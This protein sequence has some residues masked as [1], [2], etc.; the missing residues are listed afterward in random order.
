MPSNPS[1]IDLKNNTN[2]IILKDVPDIIT[3]TG[4]SPSSIISINGTTVTI[5]GLTVGQEVAGCVITGIEGTTVTY[6]QPRYMVPRTTLS[7]LDM[8][9]GPGISVV[10]NTVGFSDAGV[11]FEIVT[12]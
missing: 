2:Y 5:S 6:N 3:A 1:H 9:V 8:V 10:G 11:L 4:T 12:D 7:A